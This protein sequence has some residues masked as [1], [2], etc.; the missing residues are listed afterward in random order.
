M[1]RPYRRAL[2]TLGKTSK[3]AIAATQASNA[4]RRSADHALAHVRSR[5]GSSNS[6]AASAAPGATAAAG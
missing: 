1:R 2:S 5:A 6:H 3:P 4:K